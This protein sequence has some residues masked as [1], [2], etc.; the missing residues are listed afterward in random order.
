MEN[1]EE[2][3]GTDEYRKCPKIIRHIY[4]EN[5]IESVAGTVFNELS[6]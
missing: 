6:P 4:E 5:I 3:G 1:K 2:K